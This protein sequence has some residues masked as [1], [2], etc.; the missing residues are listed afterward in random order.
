MVQ[1]FWYC[2]GNQAGSGSHGTVGGQGCGTGFAG[3]S[4]DYQTVTRLP[5]MGL[6]VPPVKQ[7]PDALF[8]KE[9]VPADSFHQP[10]W[11]PDIDNLQS[12]G[13]PGTRVEHVPQL[14]KGEGDR[15]GGAHCS[16]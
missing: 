3:R 11:N 1:T 6:A 10:G 2:Q 15:D 9:I 13:V 8:I 7:G 5:F 12:A 4:G 14:C 16:A